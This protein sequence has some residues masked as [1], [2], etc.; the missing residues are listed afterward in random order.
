MPFEWDAAAGL[1][2]TETPA[3]PAASRETYAFE[4]YVDYYGFHAGA[5]GWFFAGWMAHPWPYGHRP[6]RCVA[7][8]ADGRTGPHELATFYFREDV[9]G[10]GIGFLFFV[11]ALSALSGPLSCLEIG[12]GAATY[13]L[14]P[15]AGVRRLK[16]RDLSDELLPTLSGAEEGSQR[17]RMFD[18]V[19]G[20][21]QP[22]AVSGFIDFYGYHA[23]AGGWMLCGWLSRPWPDGQ[24]PER[25]VLSFEGGD[26]AGEA[27]A[28][29]YARPDLRDGAEGLVMFV[30]GSAT[31]LGSLCSVSF[32]AGGVRS[33]LHPAP[34]A[35]RLRE[36]ELVSRLRPVLAPLPPERSRDSLV[37][38]LNRAPYAGED[39]LDRLGDPVFLGI[40]EAILC[41][42]DG[43]LLIGWRLAREGALRS[44]RVRSGARST[45]LDLREAIAVPRPDVL[46]AFAQ[47]GFDDP[48][49]GFV[50]Y[51]PRAVLPD[52]ACYL[53]VETHRREIGF[54]AVPKPRLE[55]IAAIRRVLD[56]VDVRFGEVAPAFDRVL[57]PAIEALN[58]GRLA[59]RPAA[60][61][62]DYGRVPTDARVS[63]IVPLY[64]R[65]DFVEYQMALFSAHPGNADV[66]Y[67]YVL[68]DPPKRKEAQLLFASVFARYGIPFRAV[69]LARNMGFAPA[70]NVGLQHATGRY[71]AYLN[72]DVFPGTPDWLER[73]A[74]RL[75]ADPTLGVVG[76]ALLFEDDSVQHR[77]ISFA[78]LREFGDWFFPLHDDKGLRHDL[79]PSHAGALR[80]CLSITG[81]CMV[82]ERALAEKVGGFDEIYAVGD[83][84]DTDLC[85]KLQ[86][87]GYRC[88]VDPAVRLYHLERKSQA[89]SAL[90]WR[91]N[92]TLYNAWQHHRRWEATIAAHNAARDAAVAA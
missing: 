18:M 8:F 52:A 68:D 66:E 12:A 32:E 71:V 28:T 37:G 87:L 80:E 6:D 40:D 5:Q 54:R 35:P 44:V 13:E 15:A 4:G 63:V 14:R 81:A 46:E 43:L 82:M 59:Q 27:V 45:A 67:I 51:L 7:R 17:R 88:A 29:L 21:R 76:G 64:G 42:P 86:A 90:G 55:G 47:H 65:L 30:H 25:V 16:D 50:A 73:L 70:N 69:L 36:A 31:P 79:A 34:S 38:L 83:F 19:Q 11:R 91:M 61:V 89:S 41:G 9:S 49:C 33:S 10:R 22:G 77:G 23:A 62:V 56:V 3:T 78:R 2:L 1:A 84:E 58:R 92:L 53:E 72:S 39:T 26:L 74:D 60:Q 57:G 48:R 85:L 24:P 20:S 75:E